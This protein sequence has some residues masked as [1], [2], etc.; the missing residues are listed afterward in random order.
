MKGFNYDPLQN[1]SLTKRLKS[2]SHENK[3]ELKREVA[4][5]YINQ[6]LKVGG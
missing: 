1:M 6:R 5:N 4:H 2:L 3:D